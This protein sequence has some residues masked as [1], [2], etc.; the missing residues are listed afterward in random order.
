M[1]REYLLVDINTK[2]S[3]RGTGD[4]IYEVGFVDLEDLCYYVSVVDPTMRNWTRCNWELICTGSIPYGA[5]TGLIRTERR[6]QQNTPVISADS[7]PQMITPLSESDIIDILQYR[8]IEI[9]TNP[10][11]S[12]K[13]S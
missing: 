11:K 12:V 2:L 1:A 3:K 4:Y 6:T 7:Y 8:Q 5:Y 9:L 10:H 13:S